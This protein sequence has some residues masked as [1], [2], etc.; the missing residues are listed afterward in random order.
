MFLEDTWK[1]LKAFLLHLSHC[2]WIGW[3][4]ATLATQ[5]IPAVFTPCSDVF[6]LYFSHLLNTEPIHKPPASPFQLVPY[7]FCLTVPGF[8]EKEPPHCFLKSLLHC[9]LPAFVATHTITVSD[10]VT[11]YVLSAYSP[12]PS[13][14][15]FISSIL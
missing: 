14:T 15:G 2:M 6:N 5:L 10:R 4:R 9:T 8:S 7:A 1:K 3:R 13:S 12:L 11:Q